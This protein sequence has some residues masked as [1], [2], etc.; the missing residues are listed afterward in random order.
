MLQLKW[1]GTAFGIAGAFTVALNIPI[2]GW[3][4]VLFMVS[5]SS[6]L[7]VS[8]WPKRD[9]DDYAPDW[10]LFAIN[11]AFSA[12]NILGIVRWLF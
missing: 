3:G 6:W 2:S 5:S 9:G 7:A 1:I 12:A 8:V 4:F 11:L 10:P